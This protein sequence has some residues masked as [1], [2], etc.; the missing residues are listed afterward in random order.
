M[1]ERNRERWNWLLDWLCLSPV[2]M[3]VLFLLVAL[4]TLPF[5]GP[6]PA[7]AQTYTGTPAGPV[8]PPSC[9]GMSNATNPFFYLNAQVANQPPGLYPCGP[10]GLFV[11]AGA[12]ITPVYYSV[13][14]SDFS[15]AAVTTLQAITGL[16]W[17][18]PANAAL[19]LPFSCHLAYSQATAAASDAFGIQDV[20]VAPTNLFAT[21]AMNTNVTATTQANL[22]TLT[23]TT[24]TAIVTATPSAITTI[25]NAD[26]NGFIEQPSNA[27]ASVVQIMVSTATA[28]DVV[29]VKRGSFCRVN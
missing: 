1:T 19:N 12:G 17:T 29:T 15:T 8:L 3:L 27:S 4:L 13:A 16:S 20:T 2:G 28:A 18:M 25:W 24:A 7:R 22:P 21:G 14:G 6:R 11:I 26:L 5:L 9:N 23:T 10:G